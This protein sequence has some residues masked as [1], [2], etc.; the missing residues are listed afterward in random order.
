MLSVRRAH[1]WPV[2]TVLFVCPAMSLAQSADQPGGNGPAP[3]K[4]VP[5][6]GMSGGKKAA[7]P[8]GDPV[9]IAG[10]GKAQTTLTMDLRK[11]DFA[12]TKSENRMYMPSGVKLA[13]QRPDGVVKEP[14]YSGTPKY[15]TI[16]VGNGTPSQFVIA[17][18]EAD[19]KEPQIYLDL[20]GDGDLTNDGTGEWQHKDK[21]RD[22]GLPSY[23]GTWTFKPGWKTADGGNT[24]GEYALNFYWQPGRESLNYYNASARVGKITIEGRVFD[25]TLIE[26]DADGLFNKL[27]DP[28]KPLVV[29][30]KTTKPVWLLLDGDQFDIRGTFPFADMNY[31]A[32]VSDD[33]STLSMAPTM[34]VVRVPS[35]GRESVTMLAAGAEAPDFEVLAWKPGQTRLDTANRVKLSDFRGKKI[36]VV[37]FWATWCGPCMKGIPHMSKIAE[38]VEGQDVVVM[39]VN[40]SDDAAPFVK[41]ATGKGKDYKF[42]LARDPAGRDANGNTIARKLYGVTGIPATF[43]IDKTGKIAAVVSGYMEGD[44]K[45]E[46]YLKGLGVK[47]D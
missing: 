40:T 6:I 21:A 17:V 37:D 24:R 1:A 27:F 39:A 33:G 13:A 14:Q 31:L 20:N 18:D 12:G 2:L 11:Y 23:Q 8:K 26:N 41:F 29:G 5:M 3:S 46:N 30:E 22:G 9:V 44:H 38:A 45:V 4:A 35:P 32:R 47:I 19:G 34:K 28:N 16:T 15:A 10:D 7:A 25:V 36:V 43:I 42:M